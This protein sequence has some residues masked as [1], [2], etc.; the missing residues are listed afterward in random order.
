MAD[1]TTS[2][3][4]DQSF[5]D[6]L[7][8]LE[9]LD[10]WGKIANIAKQAMTRPITSAELEYILRNYAY[11]EIGDANLSEYPPIKPDALRLV[12]SASG[13]TIHDHGSVL[14]AAPGK[15]FYRSNDP[16]KD[17]EGGGNGTV[18][19][20]FVDTAR[21]MLTIAQNRWLGARILGGYRPMQ[22]AAYLIAQA[23]NYILEGIELVED[24]ARTYKYIKQRIK[25]ILK[26]TPEPERMPR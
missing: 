23:S 20:Q 22:F 26:D 16:D 8:K 15:M 7:Q 17:G 18:V 13:W 1:E 4:F 11:L 19:Q 9:E 25:P 6:E 14:R 24:E 2:P 10:E 3:Y 12:K 5:W 21:D